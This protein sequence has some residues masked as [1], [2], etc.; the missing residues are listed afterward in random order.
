M[1]FWGLKENVQGE[2]GTNENWLIA[3]AIS[4]SYKIV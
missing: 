3:A 4:L 1:L 2:I